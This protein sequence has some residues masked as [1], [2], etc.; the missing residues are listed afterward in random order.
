[1]DASSRDCELFATR[2]LKSRSILC[3]PASLALR[4]NSVKFVNF[5]RNSREKR[6]F[7][8][9]VP[10]AV[11]IRRTVLA[12]SYLSRSSTAKFF[13]GTWRLSGS[14]FACFAKDDWRDFYDELSRRLSLDQRSPSSVQTDPCRR[15]SRFWF[16][17]FLANL[18]RFMQ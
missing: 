8:P 9:D 16:N 3:F 12:S 11:E 1:M 7:E 13:V 17:A 6:Y 2:L 14:A 4:N 15:T 10:R 18:V 5:V